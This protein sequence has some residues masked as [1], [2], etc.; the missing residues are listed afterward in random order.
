MKIDWKYKCPTCGATK[1]II[2]GD[3]SGRRNRP[4]WVICGVKGC[5]DRALPMDAEEEALDKVRQFTVD[6]ICDIF[7]LTDDERAMLKEELRRGR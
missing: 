6:E 3:A 4:G 1:R 5:T 7:E 2:G